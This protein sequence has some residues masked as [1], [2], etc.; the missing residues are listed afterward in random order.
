MHAP[1]H[2]GQKLPVAATAVQHQIHRINPQAPVRTLPGASAITQ[3]RNTPNTVLR[4]V[5]ITLWRRGNIHM[6]R[7][8]VNAL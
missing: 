1:A 8:W 2:R 6:C 7:Q 5:S 3:V 4:D